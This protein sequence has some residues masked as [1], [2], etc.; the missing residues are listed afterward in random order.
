MRGEG[1]KARHSSPEQLLRRASAQLGS[2]LQLDPREARLDAQI[3][4]AHALGVNRAWLAAHDRD[5]MTPQQIAAIES[6]IARRA[7]G[8]P[9]AYLLG[10]REFYGR[11]FRVTADVLIPRPD[12]ELLVEAALARLPTNG[13]ARILDLGTGSGCIAVTLALEVPQAEV[14]AVDRSPAALAVARDNADLLGAVNVHFAESDWY[15][16]LGPVV[17]AQAGTKKTVW[18]PASAGMTHEE[19]Q[20]IKTFDL[21]VANPPY[22]AAADPHLAQGDLRFEPRGALAA[23]ADGLDDL[24]LIIAGAPAYLNPGGWLLVEHGWEQG[25]ACRALFEQQGYADIATLH[26]LAGHERVTLGACR[27]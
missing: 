6:L 4:I 21:I 11:M 27:T 15:A 13:P 18:I 12:T 25:A 26:D 14:S 24:R 5:L 8:E 23:G 17:P 19:N 16:S 2:S 22:V 20:A 3:L 7:A 10:Q 9:V 1:G